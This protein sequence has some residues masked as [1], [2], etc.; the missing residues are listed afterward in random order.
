M[1]D[2]I[3]KKI[4]IVLI[5]FFFM[6]IFHS[7]Y[8]GQ[9]TSS[10]IPVDSIPPQ[11]VSSQVPIKQSTP[12]VSSTGTSGITN[13]SD[14][15]QNK[16][17]ES[18]E[19]ALL[20]YRYW[21]VPLD[22]ISQWPWNNEKY[23]PVKSSVFEEWINILEN[24]N[25]LNIESS[26]DNHIDSLFLQAR[27]NTNTLTD[28]IGNMKITH[29][30]D[31]LQSILLAPFS[32]YCTKFQWKNNKYGSISLHSD[33]GFWLDK[34]KYPSDEFTFHWSQQGTT[35]RQG[36]IIFDFILFQTPVTHLQLEIPEGYQP[37]LSSGIVKA[38]PSKEGKT[39]QWD[40]YLSSKSN[41]R[42]T[43]SPPLPKPDQQQKSGYQQ[44]TTYRISL[45]GIELNSHF[46]FE[47]GDF[48]PDKLDFILPKSL[49]LTS[50][51][52]KNSIEKTII[53]AQTPTEEGT[54]ITLQTPTLETDSLEL[55]LLTFTPWTAA[56]T[57]SLPVIR[58]LSNE[59]FWKETSHRV[60]VV[61]PLIAASFQTT[62]AVESFDTLYSAPEGS[63]AYFFK[64][65]DPQSE[66]SV[67]LL[68]EK[69]KIQYDSATETHFSRGEMT[70][71]TMLL[72]SCSHNGCNEFDLS[73]NPTWEIDTI[74][75]E[76]G[77][78]VLWDYKTD[79]NQKN[80][81]IHLN[82]KTPIIKQTPI[83]LSITARRVF[84]ADTKFELKTLAPVNLENIL[85]GSHFLHLQAELPWQ[86]VLTDLND[87]PFQNDVFVNSEVVRAIFPSFSEATT[88]KLGNQTAGGKA[89]LENIK[90][91][92]TTRTNADIVVDNDI[93]TE[94][95]KI[96]CIPLTG[97]RI[98]R[99]IVAFQS[100]PDATENDEKAIADVSIPN[101]P[102]IEE[103][104]TSK[105]LLPGPWQWTLI[106]DTEKSLRVIPLSQ[107]ERNTL[108]LPKNMTAWELRLITSRSVPFDVTVSRSR[109]FN[110]KTTVPLILLPETNATPINVSIASIRTKPFNVQTNAMVTIPSPIPSNDHFEIIEGAFQYNPE[111]LFQDNPVVL[112][113]DQV[114]LVLIP[115][116]IPKEG[117][118]EE[119]IPM[120]DPL[121]LV[122]GLLSFNEPLAWCWF[123]RFDSQHDAKGLV[124]NYISWNLENHGRESCTFTLPNEI[125]LSAV[126]AVWI[127]D[128]RITWYPE[129][130]QKKNTIRV[131]LPVNKRFVTISL[132]YFY[133]G[134]S[135]Q[136]YQKIHPSLPKCD[137]PVL[138]GTWTLWVPME[139]YTEK[140]LEMDIRKKSFLFS[141]FQHENI[142]TIRKK[143]DYFL[144]HFGN[145]E[146]LN[147]LLQ[148]KKKL[149][150][151]R[152]KKNEINRTSGTVSSGTNKESQT[153]IA[154]QSYLTWYEVLTDPLFLNAFFI[155]EKS[156][157][158]R[159]Y[160]DRYLL[161]QLGI[162]PLTAIRWSN[163]PSSRGRAISAMEN[164]G[165]IFI[166]L[167]PDIIFVS[168]PETI[169]Q[170]QSRLV[171]LADE[172]IWCFRDKRDAQ[173]FKDLLYHENNFDIIPAVNWTMDNL[174]SISP[175][176]RN[177]R[178]TQI[179]SSVPAWN[180]Y[181]VP[182][183]TISNGIF[184]IDRYLLAIKQ[185][186]CF[187][188]IFLL[189]CGKPKSHSFTPVLLVFILG[190]SGAL[191]PVAPILWAYPLS[192][193]FYGAL[194]SLL[195]YAF[196]SFRLN[197][198]SPSPAQTNNSTLTPLQEVEEEES[199]PG[200]VP[201]TGNLESNMDISNQYEKVRNVHSPS[202]QQNTSNSE[203]KTSYIV[204]KKLPTIDSSYISPNH[205]KSDGKISV[206]L[207]L[208]LLFPVLFFWISS[209]S[210]GQDSSG[211]ANIMQEKA[212]VVSTLESEN[213]SENKTDSSISDS[214]STD[215]KSVRKGR[216]PYR[217]F[218]PVDE[219]KRPIKNH[220]YWI[221]EEFYKQLEQR[222]SHSKK[223]EEPWYIT[224][225]FYEGGVN[226]N[227]STGSLSLFQLR[228]TYKIVMETEKATLVFPMMPILPDGGARFDHQLIIPIYET[229]SKNN[230]NKEGYDESKNGRSSGG[231]VFEIT[232]STPGEHI[233][234]LTLT[235]P[236]FGSGNRVEIAIPSIP[237]SRLELTTP[238]DAP[239]INIENT[240]GA[241]TQN[242]G[243]I[244]AELGPVDRLILT[245]IDEPGKKGET[246]VDVEQFFRICA[247]L[248]QTDIL[249]LFRYRITGGKVRTFYLQN[250]PGLVFSGQC[251]C[252]EA[253]IESVEGDPNQKD[254]VRIVLKTPVSGNLTIRANY[255]VNHF[256]GIGH[257]RLPR[258]RAVQVR[259][260]R[261]W[262]GLAKQGSVYFENLPPSAEVSVT[263]FMN[264]SGMTD[265]EIVAAYDL[266]R[267]DSSWFVPIRTKTE[268]LSVEERLDLA[269]FPRE[270]L[271]HY[272]GDIQPTQ[273]LL[274]SSFSVEKDFLPES[275]QILDVK[276]N[277][278]DTPDYFQE[279]NLLHIAYRTP[280]SGRHFIRI[281][282][283]T[284]AFIDHKFPIPEISMRNVRR[285]HFDINIYRTSN[286]FLDIE[287]KR[288]WIAI[289]PEQNEIPPFSKDVHSTLLFIEKA[290]WTPMANDNTTE[291]S[292]VMASGITSLSA[293]TTKN[294]T[295]LSSDQKTSDSTTSDTTT[296]NST[297]SDSTTSSRIIPT[298]NQEK[299]S[300][301]SEIGMIT[302]YY[303]QPQ[304]K[305]KRQSFLF[306][307]IGGPWE[308]VI[309][310]E[311]NV[312]HGEIDAFELEL[313]DIC[314]GTI[315]TKPVLK[316]ELITRGKSHILRLVPP[317]LLR[318]SYRFQIH[319]PISANTETL[320]F[321]KVS[322]VGVIRE[323]DTTSFQK[324]N[325]SE[326]S[327]VS[328][329]T[330]Q[331]R[332][333]R[334]GIEH[335][336]FLPVREQLSVAPLQ[337]ELSNL[338]LVS[339]NQTSTEETEN[340][341][342]VNDIFPVDVTHSSGM[343]ASD[344]HQYRVTGE[345]YSAVLDTDQS[346]SR[347]LEAE[348]W[349]YIRSNGLLYSTSKLEIKPG[350]R[351]SC[352]LVIPENFSLREITVDGITY[353]P[354][355]DK[356]GKLTIPLNPKRYS[357]SINMI[358]IGNY[359]PIKKTL[360][361]FISFS[362]DGN[363][364]GI[365]L[366]FPR[367]E[368]IPIEKTVWICSMENDYEK[369]LKTPLPCLIR[370]I[371]FGMPE[372][373]QLS[374]KG[375]P[376]YSFEKGDPLK[377]MWRLPASFQN[378]APVLYRININKM[379][380]QLDYLEVGR[381]YFPEN[382]QPFE[383]WY[384]HWLFR[385]WACQNVLESQSLPGQLLNACN[386]SQRLAV[387]QSIQDRSSS[388]FND[389]SINNIPLLNGN[390]PNEKEKL[391][392]ALVLNL[393]E[394]ETTPKITGD[395]L[396]QQLSYNAYTELQKRHQMLIDSYN[397][398]SVY[399]VMIP[400]KSSCFS[401]FALWHLY[402]SENT[403]FLVGITNQNPERIEL[404]VPSQRKF[405]AYQSCLHVLLWIFLTLGTFVLLKSIKTRRFCLRIVPYIA[406]LAG[407]F[408][409]YKPFLPLI[410]SWL[411]IVGAVLFLYLQRKKKPKTSSEQTIG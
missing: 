345:N 86:V 283:K 46:F 65:F 19:N 334:S 299:E 265:Y 225:A 260:L 392:A 101:K 306:R 30:S 55:E 347:V 216:E 229:E 397:L 244:V 335:R 161:N 302:E 372:Q 85:F 276:G 363:F 79:P 318:G 280:M 218:V 173:E 340:E 40:F 313:D 261:N 53:I 232:N 319:L 383:R 253:E 287:K 120:D 15:A 18:L 279:N 339:P 24:Q 386:Q 104:T 58:M 396:L 16:D 100:I 192:G 353:S 286:V 348:H 338:V 87:E 341:K 406:L 186:F 129:Q 230:K 234:E 61:R 149:Q 179:L 358:F 137:L 119:T 369:V 308:L 171:S 142:G 175:W 35:D 135:L 73:L 360:N 78:Q 91:N 201:I 174:G 154:G 7:N 255:V 168:G 291:S 264:I 47:K 273:P 66:I 275:V 158:P 42:L 200:F 238:P 368:G 387:F 112:E 332:N 152:S 9:E 385:W 38:G 111:L 99:M 344:F 113:K 407:I 285:T 237:S 52:W 148:D 402:H 39:K 132:E 59:C 250:D 370:Q 23:Y 25:D 102:A 6:E 388:H 184:V 215:N 178:G 362:F 128:Q 325:E 211:S 259:I 241:I 170:M 366:G 141:M 185:W 327:E 49:E 205:D 156:T 409:F 403:R 110:G 70:A 29:S 384:T 346:F 329:D 197:S 226:Y 34:P 379:R 22:K 96:S 393:S 272:Q 399:N 155:S 105:P 320:R 145:E 297:T 212:K 89:F 147:Q 221:S 151:D 337:W 125:D 163:S 140:D 28:G 239:R 289:R 278:I 98:D 131:L 123:V 159:V 380:S 268:P 208:L 354:L 374:E 277:I 311:I 378:I 401:S 188:F 4:C 122:S 398:R 32:F 76:T 252:D 196:R 381:P 357:Q 107:D 249:G 33:G 301:N 400:Q 21:M 267:I 224:D 199:I 222:I 206:V 109:P 48:I 405:F 26:P 56:Q 3:P 8:F 246:A 394:N 321:P 231:L 194:C 54:K 377:G 67:S 180:S 198:D 284:R 10:G 84:N 150:P 330:I 43:I 68:E 116:V 143:A 223:T 271:L 404:Y 31:S 315:M 235:M 74:Q 93:I 391:S 322:L 124:R 356:D 64:C 95:W 167:E 202:E 219:Q 121:S 248:N 254:L 71:N 144:S 195:L 181:K 17:P 165:L 50:A 44:E 217:V 12:V 375:L 97:S 136:Q 133:K 177:S 288:N 191:Y 310:Y 134:D 13:T 69:P 209:F 352:R 382:N 189:T 190:G 41:I 11:S 62:N 210:K 160:I 60:L 236:Q 269:F 80:R 164:A 51:E 251:Q 262:L 203:D 130:T 294:I 103:N 305:G 359:S 138:S 20:S 266:T 94:S 328:T 45:S 153:I 88:I 77:Q 245:R 207:L 274:R 367:I 83:R 63:N 233:L 408:S 14:S 290:T 350:K 349:F 220:Y 355:T 336:I 166:L 270:V 389:E 213:K 114:S 117:H 37:R 343:T 309:Q 292:S 304:V 1:N 204:D 82:L 395:Y 176:Y 411:I 228:V 323:Q 376:S 258:V 365:R 162:Q 126:H 2:N 118:N 127:D 326:E 139:W 333:I 373:S 75:T 298:E 342:G 307:K 243:I 169:H 187:F 351:N 108:K 90:A 324:N 361:K 281:V 293:S 247:R 81:I 146:L 172:K 316:Q 364:A 317:E 312:T 182:L 106:S 193:I 410:I 257:I 295:S 57:F 183:N 36:N 263:S 27:L 282:G 303:N 242:S 115:P 92:Y 390:D 296:S 5:F 72:V 256:S 214:T 240:C 227:P 157:T 300:V 314:S 371:N 331:A